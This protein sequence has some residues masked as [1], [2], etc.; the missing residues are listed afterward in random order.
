MNWLSRLTATVWQVCGWQ[1]LIQ[2]IWCWMKQWGINGDKLTMLHKTDGGAVDWSGKGNIRILLVNI[3]CRG[4]V[5]CEANCIDDHYSTCLVSNLTFCFFGIKNVHFCPLCRH[6]QQNELLFDFVT[7]RTL[8]FCFCCLSLIS[9][10]VSV[11][12]KLHTPR[13]L[14]NLSNLTAQARSWAAH[15]FYVITV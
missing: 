4:V 11:S 7:F 13:P 12:G 9:V 5:C 2:I 8:M 1:Y 15:Y 10:V 6:R 14:V 3:S